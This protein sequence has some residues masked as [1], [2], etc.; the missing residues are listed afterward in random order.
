VRRERAFRATSGRWTTRLYTPDQRP[1]AGDEVRK[2]EVV[3]DK[4]GPSA[5]QS[6]ATVTKT[7]RE[8]DDTQPTDEPPF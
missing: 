7:T 2:L 5:R 1:R 8:G 4:I 6:A 3:V